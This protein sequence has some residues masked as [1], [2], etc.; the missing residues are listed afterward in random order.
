M[1]RV[2]Y[3]CLIACI[4]LAHP[5]CKRSATTKL[6]NLFSEKLPLANEYAIHVREAAK[7]E[8]TLC[9]LFLG[10][11]TVLDVIGPLKQQPGG[12]ANMDIW[13]VRREANG[14]KRLLKIDW[15]GITQRGDPDT[16][17]LLRAGDRLILQA[18]NPK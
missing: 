4:L 9:K 5:S 7:P 3:I 6:P 8:M 2:W 15:I 14:E 17:F 13:L 1:R 11:E 10:S 18:R 16:N 12:I